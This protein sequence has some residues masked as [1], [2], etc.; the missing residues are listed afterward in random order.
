M[1]RNPFSA[2]KRRC[3]GFTLAELLVSVCVLV[4]IVFVVAQMMTTAT[5]V[6]RTDNKHITTDTQARTVFER[7][8]LDFAQML[9]RTDVDYYVKGVSTY[10][11]GNGHAWGHHGQT[12]QPLND[13]V[14][15]YTQV[16]GYYS[17]TSQ[18]PISIV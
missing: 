10:K 16:P 1:N 18:S 15:F 13:Q 12:T 14:A 2:A 5:A 11:H 4:M 6:T 3:A 17:S 8:A 9:K 7:M